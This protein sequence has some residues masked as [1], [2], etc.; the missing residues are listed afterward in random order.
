MLASWEAAAF[1]QPDDVGVALQRAAAARTILALAVDRRRVGAA[2][3][4]DQALTLA[5]REAASLLQQVE[6]SKTARKLDAAVNLA[7]THKKLL[8]VLQEARTL[9]EAQAAE[10]V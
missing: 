9:R 7:A 2:T 4:M 6:Q 3:D 8:N 5:E 10:S 1:L